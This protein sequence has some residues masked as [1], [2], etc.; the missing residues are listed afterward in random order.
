M[1]IRWTPT[2]ISRRPSV[3]L[4]I[5]RHQ[6]PLRCG[7]PVGGGNQRAADPGGLQR[8]PRQLVSAVASL[9]FCMADF[10]FQIRSL[11]ALLSEVRGDTQAFDRRAL[12]S[13]SETLGEWVEAYPAFGAGRLLRAKAARD[14]RSLKAAGHL[15]AAVF[16][17]CRAG[18]STCCSVRASRVRSRRLP[19]RW[20]PWSRNSRRNAPALAPRGGGPGRWRGSVDGTAAPEDGAADARRQ[21]TRRRTI[22]QRTKPLGWRVEPPSRCRR[23]GRLPREVVLGAIERSI[24]QGNRG[25]P[26]CGRVCRG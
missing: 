4:P 26:R 8:E 22:R 21:A 16:L 25:R 7:N 20:R 1:S 13:W 17:R 15:E 24:E 23:K 10:H 18:C 12:V 5:S 9:H 19:R 2:S 11:E 6:R 14:G 3:G